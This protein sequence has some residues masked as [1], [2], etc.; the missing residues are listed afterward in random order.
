MSASL[1]DQDHLRN[2]MLSLIPSDGTTI[3]NTA[4]RRAIE[5]KLQD[6]TAL[7]DEAY[8]QA[9][10]ALITNG[11]LIKGQ[12]RGG[13]VRLASPAKGTSADQANHGDFLLETQQAPEPN[14]RIAAS[15]PR[16]TKSPIRTSRTTADEA[17]I[18]SYR[19]AD[20]RV[21]NPEVGMV[22]QHKSM[23]SSGIMP[24]H[25]FIQSLQEKLWGSVD[26]L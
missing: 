11:L 13:S 3:G 9:H 16:R 15:V 8:W 1:L 26:C 25:L 12:G 19:H 2:L 10:T 23:M 18:L 14:D 4:L 6:G 17:Q 20:K 24:P 22:S 21:N 5:A 7:S